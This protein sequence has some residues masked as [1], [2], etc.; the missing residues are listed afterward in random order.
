MQLSLVIALLHVRPSQGSSSVIPKYNRLLKALA[1][2]YMPGASSLGRL[3]CLSSLPPH[4]TSVSRIEAA[5]VVEELD[6]TPMPWGSGPVRYDWM[7]GRWTYL[8][9]GHDML[10]R[11]Q[12]ELT[13]LYGGKVDLKDLG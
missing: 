6:L 5:L 9:D 4:S 1:C 12:D 10:E 7:D 2:I 3:M 13:G 8:R 11:L